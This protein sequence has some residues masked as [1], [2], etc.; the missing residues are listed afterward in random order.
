MP[1]IISVESGSSLALVLAR[2]RFCSLALPPRLGC[3]QYDS[4]LVLAIRQ[5]CVANLTARRS[6]CGAGHA[7]PFREVPVG[8]YDHIGVFVQFGQQLHQQGFAGLA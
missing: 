6:F 2:L 4:L 5:W 1:L 7:D 8:G 3:R